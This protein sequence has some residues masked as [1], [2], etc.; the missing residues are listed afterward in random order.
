MTDIHP[1]LAQWRSRLHKENTDDG[2]RQ[3]AMQAV[4]PAIIPRNHQIEAVIRAAEDENDFAPFHAL[5]EALQHPF[6]VTAEN[7]KYMQPPREEEI[8]R[9]TF[10]G[11]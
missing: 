10:C 7:E 11:T 8:V 6:I 3:Q 2:R 9:Q 4:N 5:H 1:W